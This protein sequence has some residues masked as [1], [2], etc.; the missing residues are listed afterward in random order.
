MEPIWQHLLPCFL[1]QV[2][3][4]L[5]SFCSETNRVDRK[6]ERTKLEKAKK[7]LHILSENCFMWKYN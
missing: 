6:K 3:R 5:E 4:E 2:S 7:R 1:G